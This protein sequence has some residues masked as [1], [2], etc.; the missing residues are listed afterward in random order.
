MTS[1]QPKVMELLTLVQ[2]VGDVKISKIVAS[3]FFAQER[4]APRV[5]KAVA[6]CN[7]QC[8]VPV[9]S[10]P[11]ASDEE[12]E[13]RSNDNSIRLSFLESLIDHNWHRELQRTQ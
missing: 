5:M 8:L 7:I 3:I 2:A 12:H 11:Y 13:H 10:S 1:L 6:A 9:L 4:I